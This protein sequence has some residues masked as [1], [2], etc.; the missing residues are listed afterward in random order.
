M[1]FEKL[2]ATQKGFLCI[3]IRNISGKVNLYGIRRLISGINSSKLKLNFV[4]FPAVL[5]I[6][7][8]MGTDQLKN[9][10]YLCARLAQTVSLNH[11]HYSP[12]S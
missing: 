2:N 8:Q 10:S 5:I 4:S 7:F 3:A 1:L 6:P 9:H 11:R 12:N